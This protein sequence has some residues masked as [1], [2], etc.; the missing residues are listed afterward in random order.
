MT[1][2]HEN[3]N[4]APLGM[5]ARPN[6]LLICTDQHRYDAIG[7]HPGS[8]ART[9]ELDRLGASGTVFDQ[10][11]SPSPVCSPARASMLTGL[12]PSSHGLWANGVE[13]PGRN[14]LVTRELAEAG[15][16]CGLVGKFH[17]GAA[18]QGTTEERLDDGF[19]FFRWSHDP[20]H[21]S[22]DN[23]YHAWLRERHP[24]LWEAA[25]DQIVTPEKTDF[26]H[27]NTAFDEM[28]TRGHYSTWVA[29]EVTE[30]LRTRDDRPFMMVANFF[31]PHHPFAAPPEYLE[32]YPAGSVPPPVGGPEEL[33]TK[34]AILSEASRSSY[35]GHGPSY[36]DFTAEQL[37][38]IRRTYYAMVTLVDDSVKRIL[39]ELRAAGLERDTLVIFVSD[40]G[41]MLGDH[42]LLLKGPM[43][44]DG[45]I[46]VPLILSWPERVP[47][48]ERVE[49]FVSSVDVAATIRQATGLEPA[50]FDQG[51]DLVA[52]ANGAPALPYAWSEYRNSG[53]AYDP[54]VDTTMYR[55]ADYK[56]VVWHGDADAGRAPT[57]ELYDLR[58]DPDEVV[59]RWDDPAYLEVRLRLYERFAD[60]QERHEDRT[61]S[62][63]A[64]W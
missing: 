11:Y 58:L 56:L 10:A 53:Y 24:D 3:G 45:A 64:P 38:L 41:E 55:D 14:V 52:V 4:K 54:P 2:T 12:Y 63:V 23:A 6:I 36:T 26:K 7:T 34:P 30:F 18:F 32:Q 28:P 25:S 57:G 48:G 9:P 13:L 62:R 20:F 1:T 60:V 16:R 51:R 35:V 33:A 50:G 27:A 8:A 21:G 5:S 15:Y 44:Y 40:H 17:L 49:G 61:A 46:R 47:A 39:D 43:M 59:N 29:E 22:P 42:G 31:D 37:D 19:E